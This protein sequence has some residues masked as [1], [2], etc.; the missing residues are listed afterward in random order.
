MPR[1]W[2]AKVQPELL[3]EGYPGRHG[4]MRRE[5]R[6]GWASVGASEFG[7]EGRVEKFKM[8]EWSLGGSCESRDWPTARWKSIT[9]STL[10]VSL[11]V[12]RQR[13]ICLGCLRP[14]F[15]PGL[16]RFQ[17]S[18]NGYPL[19]YFSYV[20]RSSLAGC[21]NH[22][23]KELDTTVKATSNISISQLENV[24]GRQILGLYK[25]LLKL[26]FVDSTVLT[27]NAP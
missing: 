24:C 11:V 6:V 16:W 17:R 26:V 15:D 7:Q 13:R 18:G 9:F 25:L 10:L 20:D 27:H 22:G 19:Q 2:E 5:R 1:S 23:S 4:P 3:E 8:S 21:R 14:G 12:L